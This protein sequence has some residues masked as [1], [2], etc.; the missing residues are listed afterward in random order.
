[1]VI[2]FRLLLALQLAASADVLLTGRDVPRFSLDRFAGRADFS[3]ARIGALSV[4]RSRFSAL[5]AYELAAEG[6]AWTASSAKSADFSRAILR[7]SVWDGAILT[8][9]RFRETDLRGARF[10]NS[11]IQNCNMDR[12]DLRGAVFDGTALI[13]CTFREALFNDSS[14][15]PF[16]SA[17][18][19]ELGMIYVP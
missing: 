2:L 1:M 16:D 11:E 15:L 13:N 19:V 14:R 3:Y 9:A 4:R 17:A 6:M 8:G 18:A 10:V 12:A 5:A 7:H